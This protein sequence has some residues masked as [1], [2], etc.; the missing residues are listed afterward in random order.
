MDYDECLDVYD[1]VG[2]EKARVEIENYKQTIKLVDMSMD[3]IKG[4]L[5]SEKLN[6]NRRMMLDN[7]LS[8]LMHRRDY[9]SKKVLILNRWLGN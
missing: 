6:M 2:G 3:R 5:E 4:Q 9:Y 7:E 1:C 8:L